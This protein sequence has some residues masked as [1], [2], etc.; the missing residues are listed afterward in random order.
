MKIAA[1]LDGKTALPTAEPVDHR[2]GCARDGHAWRARACAVLT[3]IG[4]VKDDDPQLTVR[5]VETP[6]QPLRVVVDSRLSTP[7]WRKYFGW[8]AR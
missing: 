8:R 5:E 2:A 6:R 1:S 3:G 4:T 7:G